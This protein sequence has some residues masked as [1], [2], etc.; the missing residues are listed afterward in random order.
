M[1]DLYKND[2]YQVY[3]LSD[4]GEISKNYYLLSQREVK[5]LGWL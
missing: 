1:Y 2:Y 3:K 5:E 4:Y